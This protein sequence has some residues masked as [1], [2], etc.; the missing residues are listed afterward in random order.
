MTELIQTKATEFSIARMGEVEANILIGGKNTG[1][2]APDVE[3]S[4]DCFSGV[5]KYSLNLKRKNVTVGSES[6]QDGRLSLRAGNETDIWYI[7]ENGKFKWDIQFDSKPS[8]NIFEWEILKSPGIRFGFQPLL[9]AQE[10]AEGADR[11]GNVIGSYSIFCDR[12]NHARRKD[13]STIANYGPSKLGHIYRPLCIDADDK[14]EW[15]SLFIG[16][17]I[18]RITIPQAF[19]DSA[20]YPMTLDPTL[21]YTSAGAS[22]DNAGAGW[23]DICNLGTMPEDGTLDS[24]HAYLQ[25]ANTS[26]REII[27]LLYNDDSGADALVASS[28]PFFDAA[29]SSNVWVSQTMSGE[30][31]TNGELYYAGKMQEA[32]ATR[33]YYDTDASFNRNRNQVDNWPTPI[34]PWSNSA[35]H[36]TRRVSYYLTYT[37]AAAGRV[38][39]SL[40]K[41]GGLAGYG[42]IAGQGG[43]LAG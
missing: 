18:M 19:I 23:S 7:D 40:A 33:Y 26:A 12:Q 15:A 36:A 21:G 30:A 22:S 24:L 37:A 38:M 43:G 25:L 14:T 20:K 29:S 28:S 16:D 11:P 9:T 10:M 41:H 4:F 32:A 34:D 27:L 8:T 6:Y 17:G 39:S 5:R 2:V 3:M 13:G 31:L 42:G 35:T 1:L